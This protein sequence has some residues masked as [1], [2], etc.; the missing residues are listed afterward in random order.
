MT[1][2]VLTTLLVLVSSA[3]LAEKYPQ[4][5]VRANAVLTCNTSSQAHYRGGYDYEANRRASY[6]AC[7]HERGQ[8][9]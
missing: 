5:N 9:D 7:M 4:A 3:A 2:I 6:S 8:A 1:K